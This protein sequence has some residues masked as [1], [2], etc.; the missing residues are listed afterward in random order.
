MGKVCFSDCGLFDGVYISF[1]SLDWPRRRTKELPSATRD[2]LSW[3]NLV[4]KKIWKRQRIN[5]NRLWKFFSDNSARPRL[6]ENQ[7]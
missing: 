1:F 5:F 2:K 4:P 3:A 6:R 7:E